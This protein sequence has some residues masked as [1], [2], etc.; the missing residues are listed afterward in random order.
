MKVNLLIKTWQNNL[1]QI[2]CFVRSLRLLAHFE[3]L[4]TKA[5]Q[6]LAPEEGQ[7]IN[8]L[9]GQKERCLL[10][11]LKLNES[12]FGINESIYDQLRKI[13]E[14]N[15]LLADRSTSIS[16]LEKVERV[17]PGCKFSNSREKVDHGEA[18]ALP[19]SSREIE[20]SNSSGPLANL[21]TENLGDG[22]EKDEEG[23]K[24]LKIL[25]A[26]Q[27]FRFAIRPKKLKTRM[28]QIFTKG[29][30]AHAK[31]FKLCHTEANLR[32]TTANCKRNG[33][34]TKIVIF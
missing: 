17:D 28:S 3:I 8:L 24:K 13:P 7:T 10:L 34:S 21:S 23:Q 20:F 12:Q 32:F 29:L 25:L 19:I 15:Q 27:N 26:P 18:G 33:S 4:S 2:T 22:S 1:T 16:L 6:N 5:F 31:K 14:F 9:S 11:E 30:E